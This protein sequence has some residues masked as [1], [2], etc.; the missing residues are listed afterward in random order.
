MGQRPITKTGQKL[1][2]KRSTTDDQFNHQNYSRVLTYRPAFRD[3]LRKNPGTI[4]SFLVGRIRANRV[5]GR[6]IQSGKLKITALQREGMNHSGLYRVNFDNQLFFVKEDKIEKTPFSDPRFD[7]AEPQ[8]RQ[9]ERA[10]SFAREW[11]VYEKKSGNRLVIPKIG[12][13]KVEV[14]HFQLAWT[15]GYDSFLV[16]KFY[17]GK[18]VEES[19]NELD[20]QLLRHVKELWKHLEWS[21]MAD[22]N[23]KNT[24]WCPREKKIVLIDLE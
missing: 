3:R 22:V 7:L 23:G 6:T 11:E 15:G 5:P 8:A 17:E 4:R 14:S 16:T 19:K 12:R 18:T 24:I 21:G 13:I 10:K 9:L 2:P 1:L 20:P